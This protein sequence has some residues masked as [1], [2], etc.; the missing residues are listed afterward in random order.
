MQ[1]GGT[2][3]GCGCS[4]RAPARGP[5]RDERVSRQMTGRKEG[6]A[7]P[8]DGGG[9]GQRQT[10]GRPRQAA[11]E[12]AGA[13]A[14]ARLLTSALRLQHDLLAV[15]F[16]VVEDAVAFRGILELQAVRDDERRVE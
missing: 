5:E 11:G 15:V 2:R 13:P 1:E 10:G 3:P 4:A 12:V 8:D 14:R 7:A 16:L 6:T 9:Q